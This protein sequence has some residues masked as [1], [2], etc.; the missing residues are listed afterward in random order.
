MDELLAILKDLHP[1]ARCA[2]VAGKLNDEN[3][4]F[5]AEGD[6][7]DNSNLCVYTHRNIHNCTAHYGSQ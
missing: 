3:T 2:E 5:G 7:Q 4:V 1:D 6:E